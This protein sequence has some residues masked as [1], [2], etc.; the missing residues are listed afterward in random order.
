M[1]DGHSCGV[2]T[3]A[4]QCLRPTAAAST[5]QALEQRF[6]AVR[7]GRKRLQSLRKNTTPV[8]RRA[9]PP[10]HGVRNR[11]RFGRARIQ[12][13]RENYSADEDVGEGISKFPAPEDF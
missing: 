1:W 2:G 3:P 4:R 5:L 11:N 9:S 12:S 7:G 10:V 6:A 13:V 8:E